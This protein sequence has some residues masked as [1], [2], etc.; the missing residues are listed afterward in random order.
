LR[1]VDCQLDYLSKAIVQSDERCLSFAAEATL[2]PIERSVVTELSKDC[3]F[4][5]GYATSSA[6]DQDR[7]RSVEEMRVYFFTF[8]AKDAWEASLVRM[9]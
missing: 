8:F 1:A 4:F 7:A 5:K 2:G 9:E 3:N 6:Q